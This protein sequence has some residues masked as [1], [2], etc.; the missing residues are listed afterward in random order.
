MTRSVFPFTAGRF[1]RR[2][3]CAARRTGPPHE[4]DPPAKSVQLTLIVSEGL[5]VIKDTELSKNVLFYITAASPG[6]RRPR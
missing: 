2:R 5:V 6:W 4:S 3:R 1:G